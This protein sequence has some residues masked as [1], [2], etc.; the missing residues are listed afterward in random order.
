MWFRIRG[1]GGH[2]SARIKRPWA[3]LLGLLLVAGALAGAARATVWIANGA[4][5]PVLRVDAKGDAQVTWSGGSVLVPP[6]G[7]LFHGGSLAGA[8]V[9]KRASAAGI[10]FAVSVRRTPDGRRWALQAWQVAPGGPVELHLARWDG[11]PTQ[12]TLAS[13]GTRLSGSLSY[14]GKPVTG[15]SY[16]LEGKHPR[17]YVDLDCF[18][19]GGK[20]GWTRMIGVAPKADG[21]F[22]IL[23]RPNWMGSRFRATVLGPNLGSTLAP[24]AEA[25]AAGS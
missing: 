3:V 19:C 10:P 5:H 12:L 17:I 22:S 7:L 20:P 2:P 1:L 24:D 23:L 16:T 15:T 6:H 21:S 8:D 11:Q 14:H 18:A 4:A 25:T 13:D 9:S